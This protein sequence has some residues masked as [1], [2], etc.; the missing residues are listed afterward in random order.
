MRKFLRM[1]P[2]VGGILA[3]PVSLI[4]IWQWLHS[5]TQLL[6]IVASH[7]PHFTPPPLARV[8]DAPFRPI[9]AEMVRRAFDST[10][11]SAAIPRVERAYA[12]IGVSE[13][14]S[15]ML[16]STLQLSAARGTKTYAGYWQV[17]VR[18]AGSVALED[19]RI[20]LPDAELTCVMPLASPCAP[21]D[22][23]VVIGT[24]QP[25]DAV[26]VIAWTS[27]A[28]MDWDA[29]DIVGTHSKGIAEI[30]LRSPVGPVW[31][32]LAKWWWLVLFAAIWVWVS[33]LASSAS[34][35]RG[36]PLETE[37]TR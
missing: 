9:T 5:P 4:A 19:V 31:L 27:I 6:H 3:I 12:P 37:A 11:L 21:R 18:N 29:K 30:E 7:G 8:Q 23:T 35:T 32:W 10:G 17:Q 15:G 22:S 2:I 16:D 24:M 36:S 1:L 14:I 34:R 28:P 13:L 33:L 25:L 20:R 26:S